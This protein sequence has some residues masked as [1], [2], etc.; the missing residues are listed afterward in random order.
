MRAVILGLLLLVG[1]CLDVDLAE[2][3]DESCL[4][5]VS[6]D[7]EV[8]IVDALAE[9]DARGIRL[10]EWNRS[11]SLAGRNTLWL[12]KGFSAANPEPQARTLHHELVHYCQRDK[13][14][15]F[16]YVRNRYSYE[17]QAWRQGVRTSVVA[18]DSC[19]AI[20]TWMLM[21]P[22]FRP[23]TVHEGPNHVE[24]PESRTRNARPPT[25]LHP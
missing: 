2:A 12:R 16:Q 14:G 5:D 15:P 20:R 17:L 3:M 25:P 11:Y 9:L 7:H 4:H 1:G 6:D 23:D 19:E 18:G 13:P 21:W 22:R 8:A 24:R 10:V